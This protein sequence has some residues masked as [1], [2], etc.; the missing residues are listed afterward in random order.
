VALKNSIIAQNSGN[1]CAGSVTSLGHNLSGDGSCGLTGSG[2]LAVVNPL[3]GPLQDNGGPGLTHALLPG[4]PAVDHGDN[5]GCPAIDHRGFLRPVD[6][7]GDATATCDIGAYESVAVATTLLAAVLPTER[8]GLAGGSPVTAFATAINTGPAPA[9]DCALAPLTLLPAGF[10]YQTTD[11]NNALT[12][13]PNTPVT[14]APGAA[15]SFL[16]A[17]TPTAPFARIEASFSVACRNT[18]PAPVVSGVNTLF[19][20]A[21]TS[22]APDPV[23]LAA[24]TS[25]DGILRLASAGV[26]VVATVNLGAPGLL[27]VSATAEGLPVTITLCE[28][29]PATSICLA[30]PTPALQTQVA[31]GGTPTF[32]VFVSAADPIAFDPANHR[33]QVHLEGGGGGGGTSVAVCTAPLCP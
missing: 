8:T 5:T 25:Q 11:Q 3:L 33:V 13:P 7:D 15:Q 1:D 6:G 9:T 26:F 20:Q 24:T 31:A 16:L 14:I 29:N 18:A 23:A 27:T 28:T 30:A 12:G 32:G 2:D 17:V 10:L 22:P 21:T 19:L 4:S